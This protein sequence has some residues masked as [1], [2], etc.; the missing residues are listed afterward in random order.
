MPD[1]RTLGEPMKETIDAV[2]DTNFFTDDEKT[3]LEGI[4]ENADVTDAA[5]VAAAGA[6]MATTLDANSILGAVVADTPVAVAVAE[7][8]LVGRITGGNVAA[9]TAGQVLTLLGIAGAIVSNITGITGA[10][11]VTNIVSLTQAEYD[12][13]VTPNAST[14]YI[15]N[16]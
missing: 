7:Q 4:E 2:P 5:N 8:R 10:D 13:I 1:I 11:Q 9:L 6:V 16:G 12:A 3:K 15:I 14:F